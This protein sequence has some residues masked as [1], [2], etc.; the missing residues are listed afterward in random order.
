[1]RRRKKNDPDNHNLK[2]EQVKDQGDSSDHDLKVKQVDPSNHNSK[3]QVNPTKPGL[4]G[5][6]L[7]A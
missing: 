5:P 6:F 2:E 1:M 3:E 4:S 7:C